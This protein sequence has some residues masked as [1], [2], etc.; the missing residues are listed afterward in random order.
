MSIPSYQFASL[1]MENDAKKRVMKRAKKGFETEEQRAI[2]SGKVVDSIKNVYKS[3]L[4]NLALQKT[5]IIV[6]KS[7]VESIAN[8]PLQPAKIDDESTVSDFSVAT[9][10]VSK[11]R[12]LISYL[13]ASLGKLVGLASQLVNLITA[14]RDEVISSGKPAS[15][16]IDIAKIISLM[17]DVDKEYGNW[18]VSGLAK[19]LA[20]MVDGLYEVGQYPPQLDGLLNIWE[21]SNGDAREALEKIQNNQYISEYQNVNIPSKTTDPTRRAEIA[22]GRESRD[23]TG[24]EYKLLTEL[25]KKGLLSGDDFTSVYSGDLGDDGTISSSGSESDGDTSYTPSLSSNARSARSG[26]SSLPPLEY[27]HVLAESD[28]DDDTFGSGLYTLHPPVKKA[29]Y[30][31]PPFGKPLSYY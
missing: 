2:K 6:A 9:E 20:V 7:F 27:V 14:L 15:P 23:F 29:P 22:S 8:D 3:I 1:Q 10:D 4:A 26:F 28:S 24:A 11:E 19:A 21:E 25:R 13:I 18:G 12:G 31:F 30:D 17:D 16:S 5:T